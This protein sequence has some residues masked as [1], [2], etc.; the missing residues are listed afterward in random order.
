MDEAGKQFH[1]VGDLFKANPRLF[2]VDVIQSV[3]VM[4]GATS[5]IPPGRS[6]QDILLPGAAA[7]VGRRRVR[8]AARFRIAKA[9]KLVIVDLA[10]AE[11]RAYRRRRR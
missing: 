6:R 3:R 4:Y 2:N 9:G 5:F 8:P 7:A 10:P 11:D 1:L